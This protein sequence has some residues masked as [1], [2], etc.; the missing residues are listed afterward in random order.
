MQRHHMPVEWSCLAHTSGTSSNG[1]G[2]MV[3][4]HEEAYKQHIREEHF[5][6][7]E[8]TE[9]DLHMSSRLASQIFLSCPFCSLLLDDLEDQGVAQRALQKHVGEHLQALALCSLPWDDVDEETA[10]STNRAQQEN[11]D[12]S[13]KRKLDTSSTSD[14]T[15]VSDL[16]FPDSLNQTATPDPDLLK[17]AE[18]PSRRPEHS[19]SVVSNEIPAETP[20]DPAWSKSTTDPRAEEWGM[21]RNERLPYWRGLLVD[22]ELENDP[23]MAPFIERLQEE[24]N[25]EMRQSL[26]Q[27]EKQQSVHSNEQQQTLRVTGLPWLTQTKDVKKFFRDRI[28]SKGRQI[29]ES[30]G[31]L[32]PAAISQTMQTTVSFSSHEAAKRALE[33]EHASRRLTR[34][35]GGSEYI[36]INHGFEDI[37]T[38]HTSINPETGRPDIE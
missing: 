27:S 21:M 15:T 33:L 7:K 35:E 31:P 20:S 13:A 9:T 34:V 18:L 16:V 1:Q 11:H 4:Q 26:Y 37:T 32:S 29:I 3:F 28:P 30:I 38:L 24:C 8:F 23:I 22:V 36:T 17:Y 2:E 19:A 12:H 5:D 25:D 14:K 10:L 6:A